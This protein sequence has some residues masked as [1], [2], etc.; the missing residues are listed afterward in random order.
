M[1]EYINMGEVLE[2]GRV[3]TLCFVARPHRMS[4]V[5]GSMSFTFSSTPSCDKSVTTSRPLPGGKRQINHLNIFFI[6]AKKLTEFGHMNCVL[7]PNPFGPPSSSIQR[8]HSDTSLEGTHVLPVFKFSANGIL[9][10]EAS[11]YRIFQGR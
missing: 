7:E 10:A 9:V 4:F 3:G 2:E 5:L 1:G 11:N 6:K 8:N